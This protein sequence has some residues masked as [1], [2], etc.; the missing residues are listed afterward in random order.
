MLE[1]N[2]KEELNT[3]NGPEKA[4][5]EPWAWYTQQWKRNIV[6]NQEPYLY[7]RQVIYAFSLLFSVFFGGILLALNLK[8]IENRK[9]IV[10]VI[11]YALSYTIIMIFVMNYLGQNIALTLVANMIGAIPLYNTFWLKYIGKDT[12]YSTRPFSTPLGIGIAICLLLFWLVL[13]GV[14]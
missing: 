5:E 4:N 12:K 10:P 6:E 7:S 13:L 9:G 3:K 1:E 11:V 2:E 8:E 14:K